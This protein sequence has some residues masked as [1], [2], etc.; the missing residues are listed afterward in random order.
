MEYSIDHLEQFKTMLKK[1]IRNG[2]LDS[3]LGDC[4]AAHFGLELS[5]TYT[6]RITVTLDVTFEA[7]PD[8]DPDDIDASDFDIDVSTSY[9]SSISD[10][11]DYTVD[12]ICVEEIEEA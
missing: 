12:D 8:C 1:D 3:N 11:T 7:N 2:D 6:A 4:Y 5:Y 9:C 10:V